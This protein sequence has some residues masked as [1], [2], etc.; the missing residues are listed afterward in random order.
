MFEYLYFQYNKLKYIFLRRKA[1]ETFKQ[2]EEELTQ[3]GEWVASL[4][5]MCELLNNLD[6]NLLKNRELSVL[7]GIELH[8]GFKDINHLLNW[9]GNVRNN[10]FNNVPME[11]DITN[12]PYKRKTVYLSDFLTK[13]KKLVDPADVRNALF[14]QLRNLAIEVSSIPDSRT[15]NRVSSN[16]HGVLRDIFS[17]VESL[18]LLGVK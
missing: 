1:K 10:I 5:L 2:L 7:Q 13:G 12:I 17:V 14:Y 18:I 3:K 15:K 9:C 6:P 11:D 8:T 4:D 16:I